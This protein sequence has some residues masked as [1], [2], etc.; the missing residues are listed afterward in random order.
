LK[1]SDHRE[2]KKESGGGQKGEG[3]SGINLR[4]SGE[5]K[6]KNFCLDGQ[7]EHSQLLTGGERIW[8]EGKGG[9]LSRRMPLERVG[10]E[11]RSKGWKYRELHTARN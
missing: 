6:K 11:K 4:K 1:K 10:K 5:G 9:T 8:L 3:G 2:T 7:Q